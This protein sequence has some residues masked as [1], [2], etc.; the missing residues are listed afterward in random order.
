[1]E[2]RHS[3][4]A[5]RA[6]REA[7]A[8]AE[9]AKRADSQLK[10]ARAAWEE[11][12][13]ERRAAA[14]E[15]AAEVGGTPYTRQEMEEAAFDAEAD[16]DAVRALQDSLIQAEERAKEAHTQALAAARRADRLAAQ[17]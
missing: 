7:V 9:A 11:S 4:A 10:R 14:R 12:V 1:M 2:T 16:D 13:A 3:S 15:H 8:A 17:Q 5:E 6:R